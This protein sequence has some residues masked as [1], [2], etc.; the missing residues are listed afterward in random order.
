[1]IIVVQ[2]VANHFSCDPTTAAK[3]T[4]LLLSASD[5]SM[6]VKGVVDF[7]FAGVGYSLVRQGGVW[8]MIRSTAVHGEDVD[9]VLS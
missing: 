5:V 2:D 9:D 4:R 1:M 8:T 6:A 3:I 7:K